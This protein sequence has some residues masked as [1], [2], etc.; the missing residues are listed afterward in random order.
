MVSAQA[1]ARGVTSSATGDAQLRSLQVEL[2]TR[3]VGEPARRQRDLLAWCALPPARRPQLGDGEVDVW[4][5]LGQQALEL[6]QRR[7]HPQALPQF[8]ANWEALEVPGH[9]LTQIAQA[10]KLIREGNQQF[11]MTTQH[12]RDLAEPREGLGHTPGKGV[13]QVAEEPRPTEAA[14][15]YD[16]A[17][18][19]GLPDHPQRV[20]RL[21]DVAVAQNWY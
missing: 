20:A 10:R 11:S 4:I 16:H 18:D 21:P 2:T 17:V 9:V 6:G 5:E 3:S 13:S 7:D 19:S 14:T 8:T 12:G 15:T 1:L